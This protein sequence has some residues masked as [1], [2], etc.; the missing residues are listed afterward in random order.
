MGAVSRE[1]GNAPINPSYRGSVLHLGKLWDTLT[2]WTRLPTFAA[3]NGLWIV[4]FKGP[5]ES[6][7]EFRY[8]V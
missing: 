8:G 1:S 6:A 3:T 7:F 2:A 4:S 5:S